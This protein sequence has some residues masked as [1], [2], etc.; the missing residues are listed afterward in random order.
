MVP[1][2]IRAKMVSA[3]NGCTQLPLRDT[4]SGAVP[5]ARK[6]PIRLGSRVR[7]TA[8]ATPATMSR[9]AI[10]ATS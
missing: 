7:V 4:S 2:N 1:V 3:S 10:S 5:P 9:S 6:A 8:S